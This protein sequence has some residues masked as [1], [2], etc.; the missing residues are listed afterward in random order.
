MER[1][2]FDSLLAQCEQDATILLAIDKK[3]V[4]LSLDEAS[5]FV[6]C[7]LSRLINFPHTFFEVKPLLTACDA[8]AN[9]ALIDAPQSYQHA[10]RQYFDP[11]IKKDRLGTLR[12]DFIFSFCLIAFGLFGISVPFLADSD[13]ASLFGWLGLVMTFG[14]VPLWMGIHNLKG[15]SQITAAYATSKESSVIARVALDII[16]GP[17]VEDQD[18]EGY[19]A[20]EAREIHRWLVEENI[21]NIQLSVPGEWVGGNSAQYDRVNIDSV[22]FLEFPDGGDGKSNLPQKANKLHID[23][24]LSCEAYRQLSSENPSYEEF[25]QRFERLALRVDYYYSSDSDYESHPY[26]YRYLSP[27]TRLV[28]SVSIEW[29]KKASTEISKE[30]NL[31]REFLLRLVRTKGAI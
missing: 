22:I 26:M 4:F 3:D 6:V 20:L 10:K 28:G 23:V 31:S 13:K 5:S 2:E 16:N 15:I 1:L 18:L 27:I 17:N 30:N 25:K 19:E 7:P 8:D 24:M 21:D 11:F 9:H 12:F 14:I 29:V